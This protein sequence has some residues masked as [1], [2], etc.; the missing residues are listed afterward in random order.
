MH[1]ELVEE[2]G[3]LREGAPGAENGVSNGDECDRASSGLDASRLA[4]TRQARAQSVQKSCEYRPA[5][6][7][8]L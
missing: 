8:A 4:W 1:Q 5:A 2:A 3:D 6:I 7:T